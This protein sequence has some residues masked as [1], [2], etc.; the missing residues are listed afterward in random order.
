MAQ[1]EGDSINL[2]T[3]SNDDEFDLFGDEN[4]NET[5]FKRSSDDNAEAAHHQ[6]HS[7]SQQDRRDHD[8]YSNAMNDHTNENIMRPGDERRASSGSKRRVHDADNDDDDDDGD[9]AHEYDEDET[10]RRTPRD[11]KQKPR[12]A[13][14][15]DLFGDD[16]DDDSAA[17]AQ[18]EEEEVEHTLAYRLPDT[19]SIK[20]EDTDIFFAKSANLVDFDP[21]A[22]TETQYIAQADTETSEKRIPTAAQL[23][24]RVLSTVRWRDEK[25]EMG[26]MIKRES[27]ARLIRWKDGTSSLKI[28][29]EMFDVMVNP[30]DRVHQYMAYPNDQMF[31]NRVRFMKEMK[32]KAYG[33]NQ[34]AH[35]F[36]AQDITARKVVKKKVELFDLKKDPDE[37]LRRLEQAEKERLKHK[38]KVE[39]ERRNLRRG[40]RRSNKS[41]DI[42][43]SDS[44][45]EVDE[46][47][48]RGNRE[49]TSRLDRD[50]YQVDD[51]V[52]EDE[53]EDDERDDE[54]EEEEEAE[55]SENDGSD[56]DDRRARKLQKAKSSAPDRT[57]KVPSSRRR[58]D[59]DDEGAS[60]K[61]R[62]RVVD[63]D[64]SD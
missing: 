42:V 51:F 44:D 8:D 29:D 38:R 9:S 11:A 24:L 55:E 32:F 5:V 50:D 64:E 37:P 14:R 16:E 21:S 52:V 45:E 35:Q 57:R 63:D 27:N 23:R 31:R 62:K 58:D 12:R 40:G 10:D 49:L 4:D 25:D 1:D 43:L 53:E 41:G 60:R 33:I 7:Q 39:S 18:L 22:F 36:M 13:V 6:Q 2:G 59:S 28:G 47:Y 19:G 26:N 3:L 30:L 54:E 48:R 15:T 56:E 17:A 20:Q 34:R 46:R 61:K